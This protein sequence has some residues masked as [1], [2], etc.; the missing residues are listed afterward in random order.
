MKI[1]ATT[2][3]AYEVHELEVKPDG[4][5]RLLLGSDHRGSLPQS[6]TVTADVV[7]GDI[8]REGKCVNFKILCGTILIQII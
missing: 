1:P 4:S 8:C 5:I 3:V 2:P 6:G 7:D